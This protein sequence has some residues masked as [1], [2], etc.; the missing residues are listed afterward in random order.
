MNYYSS[1]EIDCQYLISPPRR[2][3]LPLPQ[4]PFFPPAQELLKL[5]KRK[6]KYRKHN[7]CLDDPAYNDKGC[8]FNPPSCPASFE[9]S[10]ENPNNRPATHYKAFQP[11]LRDTLG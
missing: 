1:I 3:H 10:P 8:H 7:T 11:T 9:P 2:P 6:H 5:N 4:S